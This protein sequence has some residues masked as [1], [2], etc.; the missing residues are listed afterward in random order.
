MDP[1]D[2]WDLF[3][4]PTVRRRR[5]G[6]YCRKLGKWMPIEI[7]E[8]RGACGKLLARVFIDGQTYRADPVTPDALTIISMLLPRGDARQR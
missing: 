2:V 4:A 5:C 7:L 8:A 6:F 1:R 3:A